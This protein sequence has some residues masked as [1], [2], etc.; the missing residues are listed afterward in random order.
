M[1]N[2]VLTSNFS[3]LSDK[4]TA[5]TPRLARS[6]CINLFVCRI[7]LTR[8]IYLIFRHCAGQFQFREQANKI[9]VRL[10]LRLAPSPDYWLSHFRLLWWIIKLL[11][12]CS[13]LFSSEYNVF[14]KRKITYI[15]YTV[16]EAS[17]SHVIISIF[18]LSQ[19]CSWNSFIIQPR[20]SKSLTMA[21]FLRPRHNSSISSHWSELQCELIKEVRK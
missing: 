3:D 16:C 2:N 5:R 8:F 19:P 14:H 15:Y 6:K 4:I 12:F 9:L 17:C 10:S 1:S 18:V 7:Y 13:T 20:L 11:F 21:V